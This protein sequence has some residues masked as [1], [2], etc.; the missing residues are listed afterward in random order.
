MTHAISSD[1]L[2]GFIVKDNS[3][4]AKN[5]CTKL[6]IEALFVMAKCWNTQMSIC[7]KLDEW[8]MGPLKEMFYNHESREEDLYESICSDLQHILLSEKI[9]AKCKESYIVCFHISF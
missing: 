7:R 8:T 4:N 2:L 6:F 9:R 3:T 5:I 1:L